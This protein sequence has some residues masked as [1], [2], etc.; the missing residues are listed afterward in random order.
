MASGGADPPRFA[1]PHDTGTDARRTADGSVP[2]DTTPP[3]PQDASGLP[4]P[5]AAA[6]AAGGSGAS[7]GNASRRAE[8]SAVAELTT[9]VRTF[10]ASVRE[11]RSDVTALRDPTGT[12]PMS[13]ASGPRPTD[14]TPANTPAPHDRPRSRRSAASTSPLASRSAEAR[15]DPDSRSSRSANDDELPRDP[16]SSSSSSDSDGLLRRCSR[17]RR[18]TRTRVPG[19]TFSTP[20]AVIPWPLPLTSKHGPFSSL[21]DYRRYLVCNADPTYGRSKEIQFRR[22]HRLLDGPFHGV[23]LFDGSDPL[24]VLA[25]LTCFRT[26]ADEVNVTLGEAPYLPAHR[27]GGEAKDDFVTETNGPH[28]STVGTRFPHTINSL[29]TRYAPEDALHTAEMALRTAEQRQ[30]KG[31]CAFY[32]QLMRLGR[33]L[34]G[35]YDPG[36]LRYFVL[37]MLHHSVQAQAELADRTCTTFDEL[38]ALSQKIGDGLRSVKVTIGK[39]DRYTK[40]KSVLQLGSGSGATA[41]PVLWASPPA[42]MSEATPPQSRY[43]TGRPPPQQPFKEFTPT[44]P[45]ARTPSAGTEIPWAPQPG[46][47]VGRTTMDPVS[48]VQCHRFRGFGHY[49]RACPSPDRA[50]GPRAP[51]AAVP[52]PPGAGPPPLRPSR[53]HYA[54][55]AISGDPWGDPLVPDDTGSLSGGEPVGA[56]PG[57]P[58]PDPGPMVD[59]PA[60]QGPGK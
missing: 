32:Q 22:R 29:L 45:A 11:L 4:D 21:L 10:S 44:P 57:D 24:A 26:A 46:G 5:T 47:P 27:M 39:A 30:D 37:K 52:G 41:E 56:A 6:T 13:T 35:M 36:Q 48:Q 8:Q 3:P 53:M 38:V 33:Q 59:P 40:T 25:F 43:P 1:P 15:S 20:M 49:A 51:P 18:R 2:D 16:R 34:M 54:V 31:A 19:R 9:L 7:P 42:T 55:P 58:Q 28:G 12:F 17:A 50:M 23:S 14:P 60:S